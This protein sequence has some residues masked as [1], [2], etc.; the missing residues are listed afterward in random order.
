[1]FWR[2][3]YGAHLQ[4]LVGHAGG[5][6]AL[7]VGKDGAIYSGSNDGTIKVWSGQDGTLLRTLRA[8]LDDDTQRATH[9]DTPCARIT[10]LAV[11][12]DDKL[13]AGLQLATVHVW[14]PDTSAR[15]LTFTVFEGHIYSS[16]WH[17]F[18]PD[19]HSDVVALAVGADG[20]VYSALRSASR[21][22]GN[23][24]CIAV[25]DGETGALIHTQSFKQCDERP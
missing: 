1:M 4:T 24:V 13:Y 10:S 8:T 6:N 14:S 2:Q 23:F 19:T 9:T 5:V 7:A 25:S 18:T 12:P 16:M 21:T 20:T 22:L 3:R 11:G 15:L 17:N